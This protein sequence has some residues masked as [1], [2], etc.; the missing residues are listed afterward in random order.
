MTNL[1]CTL[2]YL[3]GRKAGSLAFVV[4]NDGA[5]NMTLDYWDESLGPRPTDAELAAAE[6]PAAQA[7]RIAAINT[8][9]RARI[10]AVW[11]AER[12]L[13]VLGGGFGAA[14][15]VE[16]QQCQTDH[17]DASN[18]ACNAVLAAADVAAVDAVQVSWPVAPAPAP[19][20]REVGAERRSAAVIAET[21]ATRQHAEAVHAALDRLAQIRDGASPTNA[22]VIAAVRDIAAYVRRLVIIEVGNGA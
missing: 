17:V 1:V 6:L 22:Q 9:C 19:V 5:G 13:S 2:E 3:S 14:G 21:V 12:Q 15:L 10:L 20:L 11:P 4:G 16:L 8:K 7:A 18:A